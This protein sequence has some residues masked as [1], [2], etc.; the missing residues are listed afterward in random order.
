MH[1]FHL[2]H[3]DLDGY[4]CQFVSKEFFKN[5][6]FYNANY[7][8]EIKF[9]LT[10]ILS[11]IIKCSA[12]KI[13][14]LITD[15]NLSMQEASFLQEEIEK[16]KDKK[17]IKLKLL[18][19]HISGA[20]VEPLFYWYYL[21]TSKCATAITYEY[22]KQNYKHPNQKKI[23]SLDKFVDVVNAIDMWIE[24]HEYFEFGKACLR[25]IS[26]S[27][28]INRIMFDKEHREYK[29]FLIKNSMN[30]IKKNEPH[31]ILD[32]NLLKIKKKFLRNGAR[33]NTLDNLIANYLVELLNNMKDECTIYYKNHKGL[34]T[35]NLGSV[36]N[37][38][39]EFLKLN[40]D[41]DF[42]MDVSNSGKVSIRSVNRLDVSNMSE[43]LFSGGGHPN[44]AG[45]KL[46][47]FK[48]TFSYQEVKSSL[49]KIIKEREDG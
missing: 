37:I 3:T 15:L 36:S 4:G 29:F 26:D 33:N 48:E 46:E 35:Y 43:K 14:F 20:D 34:L 17:Q 28:E 32:E 8:P 31:I 5:C 24:H 41:F 9:R 30:L 40:S 2:S 1:L 21:D 25:M 39:N 12:K 7:G 18:D 13:F 49:Q 23:K 27:K 44:A 22:L 45:G 16:L 38:A 10:Q 42:F 6:S 19:H 47:D 11:D